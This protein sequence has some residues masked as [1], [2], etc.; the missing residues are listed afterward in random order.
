MPIGSAGFESFETYAALNPEMKSLFVSCLDR[1]I[2]VRTWGNPKNPVLI[3]W[4]GV[5]RNGGDFSFLARNLQKDFYI[6]AP[7]TIGR[8]FSSW[9]D[10]PEKYKIEFYILIIQELIQKLG[11]EKFAWLGTS[12]GG[13]LGYLL[14]ATSFKEKIT[15]LILNDIGPI[16][17]AQPLIRIGAYLG[18]Q[19]E[20]QTFI[21]FKNY[22]QKIYASFG[23]LE[24]DEWTEM[25]FLSARKSDKGLFTNHYDL[26]IA[27]NF[28]KLSQDIDLFPYYDQ[29]A[30]PT[31]LIRG[32]SSDLLT[33]DLAHEMCQRGP[34]PQLWVIEDAGHAPLLHRRE[35]AERVRGF[36]AS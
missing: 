6:L 16:L 3:C 5:S 22:L 18:Q 24:E 21:E 36:L 30:C 17:K 20:F 25:A 1:E 9:E 11:F 23:P 32:K 14:A 31:L 26:K 33:E 15:H 4:H 27:E 13:T 12:M 10:D 29:I 8:G 2:H 34:K 35:E 7:D 28:K 19:I